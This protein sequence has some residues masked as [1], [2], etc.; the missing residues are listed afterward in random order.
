MVVTFQSKGQN[1]TSFKNFILY[2]NKVSVFKYNFHSDVYLSLKVSA[3]FAQSNTR[4]TIPFQYKQVILSYLIREKYY[5]SSPS[6]KSVSYPSIGLLEGIGKYW[7]LPY[8]K[9]VFVI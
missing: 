3:I 5:I 1:F 9:P 4:F 7:F 2:D 8:C 6:H